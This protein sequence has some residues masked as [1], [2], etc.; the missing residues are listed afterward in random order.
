MTQ[1]SSA[2]DTN[3]TG[4]RRGPRYRAQHFW[5]VV[6]GDTVT[7]QA[8]CDSYRERADKL[9]VSDYPKCSRCVKALKRVG[10]V[11]GAP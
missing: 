11:L 8:L 6:D 9:D 1:Q 10:A 7:L 4:W 3:N 2:T 5:V